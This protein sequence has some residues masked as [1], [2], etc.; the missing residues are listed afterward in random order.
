MIIFLPY[1]IAVLALLYLELRGV[2]ILPAVRPA[3]RKPWVWIAALVASYAASIAVVWYAATTVA[4]AVPWRQ[5]LPIPVAEHGMAHP[6]A[7]E[8]VLLAIA[9]VQTYALVGLYRSAPGRTAIVAGLA[10]MLALSLAAPAFI[11]P[12][13]YAYVGDAL[14]GRLAY[15]PPNVAFPGEFASIDRLFA[16]PLLPAPYGA[17]WIAL[18][19]LATAG[20][21]TLLGKLIGLRLLGAACFVGLAA[22]MRACGFP[23][24]IVALAA[25]NPMLAQQYVADAHNDLLGIVLLVAAFALMRARP[26][27]GTALTVVAA[28]VKL[29][30]VV[31]ALPVFARI[32][33]A[34]ARYALYCGAVGAALGLSWASGDAAYFRGLTVHVPAAGAVY[35]FNAAVALAALALLALAAAGGRRLA[36]ALW[37]VP[38]MGSYVA[39]WYMTYGLPYALARR[40]LTVYLLTVLPIA[41]LLVDAKFMRPWTY[42]VALPA[43][44]LFSLRRDRK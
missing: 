19:Q 42:A 18:A 20:F 10:A 5:T 12:D 1:Y 36:T 17:L 25:V 14:L 33:P 35:F 3:Q 34:A 6:D 23:L 38:M 11:S 28:L 15:A 41:S 30:F 31:I 27:L 9:V 39:T 44:I 40:R 7:V 22:A 16:P 24:R 37:T 21:P 43:A 29:P 26:L 32:Q 8:A 2:S 4:A 13:P